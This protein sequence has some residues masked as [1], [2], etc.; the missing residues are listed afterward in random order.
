MNYDSAGKG[1]QTLFFVTWRRKSMIET[2]FL[3]EIINTIM[4]TFAIILVFRTVHII[5]CLVLIC[6]EIVCKSLKLN[7]I[8]W[9]FNGFL[10]WTIKKLRTGARSIV[11]L[12]P[13]KTRRNTLYSTW[14]KKPLNN[15]ILTA[16]LYSKINFEMMVQNNKKNSIKT[17]IL[18]FFSGF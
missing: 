18:E 5:K 2:R 3:R 7:K 4:F 9:F 17:I 13:T 6:S 1:I 16:S 14:V 8:W 12:K 11:K 15:Y 10:N